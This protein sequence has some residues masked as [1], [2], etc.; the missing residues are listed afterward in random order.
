[1]GKLTTIILYRNLLEKSIAFLENLPEPEGFL[2][3][4]YFK[5]S[6]IHAKPGSDLET[7]K[8]CKETAISYR[9]KAYTDLSP[10]QEYSEENFNL[11]VPWMLW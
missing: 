1:M 11:L 9:S 8:R 5:L 3:R 2:A 4:A 10:G 6:E 7:Q